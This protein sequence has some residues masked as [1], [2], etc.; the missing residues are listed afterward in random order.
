MRSPNLPHVPTLAEAGV[1]GYDVT[2]WVGLCAPAGVAPMRVAGLHSAVQ[3]ALASADV[4]KDLADVG[5]EPA[6][7]APQE[8]AAFIQR[9]ISK[10][11]RV[12]REAG[13]APE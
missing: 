1:T 2:N 3:T 13:I 6:P 12:V 11:L 10:W 8:L 9:D 5:Y 4:A 7:T